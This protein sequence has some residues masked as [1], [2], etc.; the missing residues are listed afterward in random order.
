MPDSP[1]TQRD[2]ES[3]RTTMDKLDRTL[4]KMRTDMEH[5]Y[6]RKDVLEPRMRG[7]EEDVQDIKGWLLWAQRL[8][9]GALFL[10]ILATVITTS[11]GLP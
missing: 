5:T 9:L 8:I 1:L 10:A 4:D 2:V 11:G 3:L 6:V 7:I